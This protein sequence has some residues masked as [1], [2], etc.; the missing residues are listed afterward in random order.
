MK[1]HPLKTAKISAR[2]DP[3]L[4][5]RA[6]DKARRTGISLTHVV[7]KALEDWIRQPDPA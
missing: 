7:T 5:R 1:E 3:H 4:K 2:L 6:L